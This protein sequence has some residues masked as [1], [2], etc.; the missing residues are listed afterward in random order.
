MGGIRCI[1]PSS[2]VKKGTEMPRVKDIPTSQEIG[3]LGIVPL[4]TFQRSGASLQS[5]VV[6]TI[7]VPN[8]VCNP[9]P[10][11]TLWYIAKHLKIRLPEWK[12][13]MRIEI[14]YR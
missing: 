4:T 3:G 5:V 13:Y 6:K 12:G 11:D 14:V 10:F 1:T 2:S 8:D 7:D 9:E